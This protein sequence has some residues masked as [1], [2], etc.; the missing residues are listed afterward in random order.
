ME[1]KAENK[2]TQIFRA[3]N[4]YVKRVYYIDWVSVYFIGN[5]SQFEFGVKKFA[6]DVC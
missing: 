2:R 6:F 3:G 1:W 4:N 5:I